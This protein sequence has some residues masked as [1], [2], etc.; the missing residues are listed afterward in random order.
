MCI[1]QNVSQ[2]CDQLVCG[3]THPFPT[4]VTND[5]VYF[6]T[7]GPE[8]VT[9]VCGRVCSHVPIVCQM[10]VG[11]FRKLSQKCDQL[12]CVCMRSTVGVLTSRKCYH[13]QSVYPCACVVATVVRTPRSEVSERHRA[14]S[15]VW[16]VAMIRLGIW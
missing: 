6:S 12:V 5:C 3:C 11:I 14:G 1:F 9:T 15:W 16:V 13:T 10:Y 8:N 7:S 2:K 4:S